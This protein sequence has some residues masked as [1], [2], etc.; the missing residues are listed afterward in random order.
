MNVEV[1]GSPRPSPDDPTSAAHHIRDHL[2]LTGTKIACGTGVCGACT[3]LVD[4]SPTA[5]C[6]LPADRLAGRSLTTVEGLHGDHPVQRAFAAHDGLQCG[7]CTPGFIM[8]A[9]VFVDTWRAEHGN[10]RP[11]RSEIADALA[12]NLCRCGAYEGIFAAVAAACA[13]E[14]DTEPDTLPPRIDAPD[15]VTGRARF[16]ADFAS[17]GT[18]EGV[19]VRATVPH[20][21]VRAVDPGGARDSRV[22]PPP[23]GSPVDP[24]PVI[25]LL[26]QEGD[27]V[28]YVGQPVAAVAAPTGES[29]RTAA[30]GVRVDY[31]P[32]PAVV[33]TDTARRPDAPALYQIGRAHV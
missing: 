27:T 33:D 19:V 14:F 26:L 29:A 24:T 21:R 5:S 32:L 23:A 16:T 7:Y 12:G 25:T 17:E 8:S 3:V 1:N 13:G 9:S 28:R 10:T 30:D 18:W 31:E 2:G 20:A 4:G 22:E 15:K 11:G 6:L